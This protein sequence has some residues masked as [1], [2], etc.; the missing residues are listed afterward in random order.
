MR[1]PNFK[2]NW[3]T[4]SANESERLANGVGGKIKNRNNTIA[5]ITRKKPH[6]C[7]KYVTY[8][9]FVCSVQPEKKEKNRT[10]F[11]V[12]GDKIDCPGEVATPTADILV[13]N[14]LQQ[15]HLYKR[16]QVH[17]NRHIQLLPR[18]TTEAPIIHLHKRQ[19]H[20]R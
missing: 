1:N 6:N 11:N 4:S 5:F 19:R 9:Q 13:E 10:R 12:G 14:P 20:P 2:T 16:S 3:S 15:H 18:D 8:G 7:R 17:D